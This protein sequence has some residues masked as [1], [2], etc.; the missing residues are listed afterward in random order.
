MKIEIEILK[1]YLE[2]VRKKLYEPL[3]AY[4]QTLSPIFNVYSYML[5]SQTGPYEKLEKEINEKYRLYEE[6]CH[7]RISQLEKNIYSSKLSQIRLN[8]K[9]LTIVL[10]EAAK[11]AKHYY[12][13]VILKYNDKSSTQMFMKKCLEE[14]DWTAFAGQL[15]EAIFGEGILV[16]L[17]ETHDFFNLEIDHLNLSKYTAMIASSEIRD[18]LD[19]ARIKYSPQ[20]ESVSISIPE[21]DLSLFKTKNEYL[22]LVPERQD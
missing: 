5:Q 20:S 13:E 9:S 1:S 21:R 22:T 17:E 3:E 6:K 7:K 10:H 8:E 15:L 4:R 12:E 16:P 11:L 18:D 19:L 14:N 2:F